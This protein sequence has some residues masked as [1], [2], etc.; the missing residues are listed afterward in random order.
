MK[1]ASPFF[2]IR[3]FRNVWFHAMVIRKPAELSGIIASIGKDGCAKKGWGVESFN[4]RLSKGNIVHI[5][6]RKSYR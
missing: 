5:A 3:A 6:C 4:G 1:V 2:R